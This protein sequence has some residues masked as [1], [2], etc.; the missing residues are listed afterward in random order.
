MYLNGKLRL[1]DENM[2]RFGSFLAR[3]AEIFERHFGERLF[4][5]SLNVLVPSPSSLPDDLDAKRPPPSIVIP[6]DDMRDNTCGDGQAWRCTLTTPKIPRPVPCWIFRRIGS[7]VD[8]GIIEL[9]SAEELV[10]PNDLWDGDEVT[11]T[12]EDLQ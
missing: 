10:N 2:H 6:K 8:R 11:I 7:T 3:N 9:L 4:N 5:G 1:N 12:V